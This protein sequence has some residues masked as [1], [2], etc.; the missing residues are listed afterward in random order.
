VQVGEALLQSVNGKHRHSGSSG[1]G[2]NS[3]DLS[4][5]LTAAASALY[6]FDYGFKSRSEGAPSKLQGSMGSLS[7]F[8]GVYQGPPGNVLLI[9]FQQ[10][11]R[12]LNAMRG[13][14]VSSCGIGVSGLDGWMRSDA[15][16]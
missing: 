12:N 14:Y 13:E 1:G 15:H 6:G 10:F 7:L 4:G 3:T 9:G 8:D 16:G 5:T 11:F 2:T